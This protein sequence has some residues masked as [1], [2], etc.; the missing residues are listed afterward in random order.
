MSHG[1]DSSAL[2]PC[3]A[4][5]GSVKRLIFSDMDWKILKS[6][7]KTCYLFDGVAGQSDA[8]KKYIAVG[9]QKEIHKRY[10]TGSRNP[11]YRLESR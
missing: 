10:L 7:D 5:A 3:I 6:S 9:V 8:S 2:V 11:W 1:L 4:N